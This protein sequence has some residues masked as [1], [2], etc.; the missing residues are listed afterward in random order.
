M[1]TVEM[2]DKVM[3]RTGCSYEEAKKVLVEA[4]Y[5]VEKAILLFNMN[6][7]RKKSDVNKIDSIVALLQSLIQ[8][9]MVNRITVTKDGETILNVP[10]NVGVV[11]AVFA[12]VPSLV[13][14]ATAF[15]SGCSVTIEKNNGSTV[16]LKS[17]AMEKGKDI[18]E[19]IKTKVSDYK[20]KEQDIEKEVDETESGEEN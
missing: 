19:T 8:K 15:V 6:H 1:I 14:V 5:S 2:V 18:S 7:K 17:Y 4:D 10:L 11:A 3:A 20:E 9:G 13:A 12:V 16:D